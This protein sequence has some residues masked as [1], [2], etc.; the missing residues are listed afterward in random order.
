MS[1]ESDD[2]YCVNVRRYGA[3]GVLEATFSNHAVPH[4]LAEALVTIHFET[5]C[6]GDKAEITIT[7]GRV[8]RATENGVNR[9]VW[10]APRG[11]ERMPHGSWLL[12]TPTPTAA[13]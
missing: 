2:L 7:R 10:M 11:G 3:L 1:I 12:S 13:G 4:E 5:L 6:P 8:M 9:L